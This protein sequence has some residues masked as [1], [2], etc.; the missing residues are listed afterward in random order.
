MLTAYRKKYGKI[1]RQ[2]SIVPLPQCKFRGRSLRISWRGKGFRWY[3]V[4]SLGGGSPVWPLADRS[5]YCSLY[6][7]VVVCS[8][9]AVGGMHCTAAHRL[10][11]NSSCMITACH[12][13][14]QALSCS[15][16][17][18]VSVRCATARVR[19]RRSYGPVR[20]E[21]CNVPIVVYCACQRSSGAQYCF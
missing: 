2:F 13:T 3:D 21:Y 1:C 19:R 20:L 7:S 18:S 15:L 8:R 17:L 5:F 14:I 6:V 10:L 12:R 4:D 16:Q 11:Y 9:L